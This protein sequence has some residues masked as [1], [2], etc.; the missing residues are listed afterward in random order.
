MAFRCVSVTVG[1]LVPVNKAAVQDNSKK[2][3][4]FGKMFKDMYFIFL[5][6]NALR[7][8]SKCLVYMMSGRQ[9]NVP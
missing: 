5:A 4:H 6:I 7:R 1:E 9:A 3:T 8:C 2:A